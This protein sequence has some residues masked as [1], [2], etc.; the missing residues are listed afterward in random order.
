MSVPSLA[1]NSL[2]V[3]FRVSFFEVPESSVGLSGVRSAGAPPRS[4]ASIVSRSLRRRS[5]LSAIASPR[6]SIR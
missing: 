5:L 2:K 6:A 1:M 4:L 3:R